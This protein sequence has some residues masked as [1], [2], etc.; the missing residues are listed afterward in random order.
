M[1]VEIRHPR[2]SKL[3]LDPGMHAID[4]VGGNTEAVF[5]FRSQLLLDNLCDKKARVA[6]GGVPQRD[7][8][9]AKGL[10]AQLA[11]HGVDVVSNDFLANVR[12]MKHSGT[13]N[14]RLPIGKAHQAADRKQML[15]I[16]AA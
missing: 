3:P 9:V 11:S 16:L 15:V 12:T 13:P 7:T 8:M 10:V 14:F 1:D 2:I 4:I 6:Q 5:F